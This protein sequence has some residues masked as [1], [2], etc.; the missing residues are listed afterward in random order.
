MTTPLPLYFKTPGPHNT[1]AVI[2]AVEERIRMGD[3]SHVVVAS[4]TGESA[5]ALAER[6][7]GTCA[8][9]IC[10]TC[11]PGMSINFSQSK[12]T[13]YETIPSLRKLKDGFLARGTSTFPLRMSKE[14]TEKL[15]KLNV[16]IVRSALPFF[17]VN[18]SLNRHA[19]IASPAAL[20]SKTLE[21]FSTGSSACA[22][23][24]MMAADAGE[25]EE[26]EEVMATAGTERGLDTAYVM[27]ASTSASILH[28][29]KGL[30]F[31]ELIAKPRISV[32]P[33]SG[34]VK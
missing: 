2:E 8:R 31:C 13:P 4:I 10:V 12:G 5:V 9:V 3:I 34:T 11:P 25:I 26:G 24:V 7:E 16:S 23:V 29:E 32:V 22:E 30:R 15:G 33:C 19:G 20:I 1:H 17:G 6:L 14:N 27:R 21:L 28:H 18:F